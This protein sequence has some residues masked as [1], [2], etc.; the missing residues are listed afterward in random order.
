MSK[1][2]I[3]LDSGRGKPNDERSAAMLESI[4][5]SLLRLV[6]LLEGNQDVAK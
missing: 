3:A 5:Y 4:A 2:Q 6:A 1:A